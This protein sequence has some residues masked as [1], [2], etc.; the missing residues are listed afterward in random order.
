VAVAEG[1]T[2]VPQTT[3]HL[4]GAGSHS[5]CGKQVSGWQWTVQQPAG[6][7]QPLLNTGPSDATLTANVAGTYTFCLTVTDDHG[8][9][10]CVK[11]CH[12]VAV[13]PTDHLHVELLWETPADPDQTHAPGADLDLHFAHPPATFGDPVF[14]YYEDLDC[15]GVRDPWFNSDYDCYWNAKKQDWGQAGTTDDPTLDL[16]DMD[17]LGP[18]N[19]NVEQPEGTVAEPA[20]YS[21]GVHYWQDQG[22]GV[23]LAT[24]RVYAF[25]TLAIAVD[26]VALQPASMWY[27]GRVHW[28]SDLSGGKQPLMQLCHQS[29]D[30]C[31]AQT[32]PS[33]PG[34]GKMWQTSGDFCV[35]P[36]YKDF[37]QPVSGLPSASNCHP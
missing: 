11:S 15:D 21:I 25:G 14:P 35:T 28:P 20:T 9:P 7:S 37:I 23:S 32:Q 24:V 8:V 33:A 34:A 31:L 27:V 22:F 4:S 6:S 19:L 3:I 26:K 12:V 1:D 18:E 36:C 13:V 29:G 30:A 10:S 16:D 17:G 5:Q 2:V